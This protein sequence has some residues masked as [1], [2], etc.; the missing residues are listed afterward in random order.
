MTQ[1]HAA[2]PRWAQLAR[3]QWTHT[4]TQ[5]PPFAVEPGP[6]QESV[7]DYPR[8]PAIVGDDRAIRVELGGVVIAESTRTVRVLET[9]HPPTFYVPSEDVDRRL[10]A[11]AGGGSRCEWKG[12]ATFWDATAGGLHVARGAWSYEHPFGDFAAVRGHLAFY[13]SRFDCFVDGERARPQLGGFYG[14][15][16]TP[17]L[18][19]PFKG[20]PGT[21]GW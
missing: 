12:D 17:E 13:A 1:S 11:D 7:W 20:D 19:G 16:V 8:P 18:V 2:L 9:A 4:G 21:S 14:G 5:R 6:G 15:W 3:E 10:L